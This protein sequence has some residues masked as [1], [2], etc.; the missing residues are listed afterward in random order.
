[1]TKV[2]TPSDIRDLLGETP[3]FFSVTF[4]K[5]TT[6]ER[7]EMNCMWGVK[8]HLK[9]GEAAYDFN[10]KGLIPVWETEESRRKHSGS[11]RP[12][13]AGYRSIPVDAITQIR[14]NKKTWNFENGYMI[15]A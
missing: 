2:M 13:D 14:A 3:G 6:G 8:K 7:R 4:T 15:E 9:G 1:M 5:R 10:A 11:I 12:G